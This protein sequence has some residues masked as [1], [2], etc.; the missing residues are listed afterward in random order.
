M[1][2]KHSFDELV[3]LALHEVDSSSLKPV[4]EKELL[5]YHIFVAL[6]QSRLLDGLVFQGG[7]SLRLCYG[8]SRFS[9]DLD[10]AGGTNFTPDTKHGIKDALQAHLGDTLGLELTVKEPKGMDREASPEDVLVDK[11]QLTVNTSPERPDLPRQKIK[12]EI[13]NIPAYTRDL[14]PVKSNYNVTNQ[15]SNLL[16]N[17]ESR[18]EVMADKLLA[19]PV[20][21]K[22]IRHR[23]IWDLTWLTQNG[24]KPNT[25][26]VKQKASDYNIQLDTYLQ[27]LDDRIRSLPDIIHGKDFDTQMRRFI[28]QNTVKESLERDGFKDYLTREMTELLTTVHRSLDNSS[29]NDPHPFKM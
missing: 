2:T 15:Y 23:D 24:I 4:I 26:W 28:D 14:M 3:A 29:D 25:E 8:S 22:N 16:I 27:L 7:T 6:H 12:L 5:H 17:A 18:E 11:W 10:F 19:L 21:V 9:E 20:C 1:K 13:A